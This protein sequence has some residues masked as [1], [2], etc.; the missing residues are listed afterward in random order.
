MRI[1]VLLLFIFTQQSGWCSEYSNDTNPKSITKFTVPPDV[2]VEG[3]TIDCNNSTI[4]ISASSTTPG[5]TF[6]WDGPGGFTSNLPN[7]TVDTP[8]G[9]IVTVTAPDG[10]TASAVAVVDEDTTP[11]N[12]YAAGGYMEC[13]EDSIQLEG[14][15]S[16]PAISWSWQG[17][18]GFSSN[19]QNPYAYGPGAYI[20]TVTAENGCTKAAQ[21][22]I[23]LNGDVPS[24]SVSGENILNCTATTIQLSGS[25]SSINTT[26]EWTGPNNFQSDQNNI[27]ITVPGNY[28]FSVTS[29]DGCTGIANIEITQD[30]ISPN[31]NVEG[32]HLTCDSNTVA[33][34]SAS[35]TSNISYEWSLNNGFISNDSMPV[36]TI[37]GTYELVIT[38]ENGC[39]AYAEAEVT[40]DQISPSINVSGGILN[41]NNDSIQII[42]ASSSNDVQF[43]WEGPNNFTSN[44]P[45]PFVSA[46]GNYTLTLTSNNGCTSSET[47]F[48]SEDL[49]TPDANAAGG[50]LDCINTDI[51]LSA[52]SQ[53]P[54]VSYFWEGPN[55]FESILQNPIVSDSGLYVLTVTGNNGC[56]NIVQ[57]EVVL[58]AEL[59]DISAIG[60]VIDCNNSS[61]QLLGNSS[62]NNA[63]F[64]WE[65]PNNF[66]STL[67]NPTIDQGGD[68]TLFVTSVNG[69]TN[70]TQI[71][72]QEDFLVPD[73]L[74]FGDTI[75]CDN[76][77]VSLSAQSNMP[78]IQ[79]AWEG[80]NNF[81]SI[82]QNPSVDAAGDYLLTITAENGC[83]N[84][85]SAN[86]T[87]NADF[88]IFSVS[89]DTLTCASPSIS[90]MVNPITPNVEFEWTGPASFYSTDQNPI[91]EESG[92]YLLLVIG[93]NGCSSQE[94]I[95]VEEDKVIPDIQVNGGELTCNILEVELISNTTHGNLNY[96]W[97]SNTGIIANTPNIQVSQEGTYELIVTGTNGCTNSAIATV[98]LNNQPPQISGTGGTLTCSTMEVE[99]SGASNDPNS[100]FYWEGP[101]NFTSDDQ[102]TKAT[103]SGD[104]IL[105]VTGT[106]GC[107]ASQTVVVQE[108]RTEPLV[109]IETPDYLSC[110]T[111]IV[112]LDGTNSDYGA[113]FQ[114]QWTTQNGNISDLENTLTPTVDSP[115]DY[116]LTIINTD[117]GCENAQNIT[118]I[119]DETGLGGAEVVVESPKCFGDENGHIS[120]KS[121]DGGEAPF[122]Y[123]LNGNEFV[124]NPDFGQLASGVYQLKIQDLNGCEWE[125]EITVEE[126]FPILL[127]LG[128]DAENE[129][130][131]LGDSVKLDL[132]IGL[133]NDQIDTVIWNGQH[134][135]INCKNCL[136]PVF[137]PLT[138]TNYSVE[139]LT[140]NGCKTKAS[141]SIEVDKNRPVYVPNV[142]SPNGDGVNDL[143]MIYGGTQI[144]TIHQFVVFDRWG[145]TI[146][147]ATNFLPNDVAGAWNGKFRE[148]K[149]NSDVFIWF[150]EIEFTDGRSEIFKGNVLLTR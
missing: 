88:P 150:A 119:Y 30:T 55:N 118:V 132:E 115:G 81:E 67:Q 121:V 46:E 58:D 64:E 129:V 90:L 5:V 130:I 16:L 75:T 25:T 3:G 108:N 21:G 134:S 69:C 65:G 9:Y 143:F 120:V 149:L 146:F 128:S 123:S 79:Y 53:T 83:T 92:D 11:P 37:A 57:T 20:L 112:S 103:Q 60:G 110:A 18:N 85:A 136:T 144:S 43:F 44:N 116:F 122:L 48:V 91:V 19:E 133:I 72:V 62:T 147:E 113:N 40:A 12:V 54:N 102:T 107:E 93:E 1:V 66:Q 124:G 145:Q 50:I 82:L 56:S 45:E 26:N 52:N 41:C 100:S 47:A 80:P 14:Q 8:G 23:I 31:V 71:N 78:N 22:N 27:Q 94:S 36:V 33:L 24:V 114:F 111:E 137:R 35:N 38:A 89:A 142:F 15:S 7:P 29:Q 49:S 141:I 109:Q 28:I 68:Y 32:G 101:G 4:Q 84:S 126:V 42:G 13:S 99:I 106:N 70:Q 138:T 6:S 73:I 17:P 125:S 59:P 131:L 105:T 10:C 97:A 61:I 51:E 86:V 2:S 63:Q 135:N 104:Y 39:T 77:M 127:S 87:E 95:T 117:N 96:E 34:F 148:E 140:E 98:T 74:V 76:P 139:I